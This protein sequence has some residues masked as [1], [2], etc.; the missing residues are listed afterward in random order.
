MKVL[1]RDQITHLY[2][3]A[4]A[5]RCC[6]SP[7][8]WTADENEAFNFS[9]CRRALAYGRD[10]GLYQFEVVMRCEDQEAYALG[11]DLPGAFSNPEPVPI[12][13]DPH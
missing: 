8:R 9:N 12:A 7:V 1:I 5:G 10:H 3:R 4:E 13:F 2:C 6:A 11:L